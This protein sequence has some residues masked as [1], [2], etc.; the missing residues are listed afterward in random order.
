MQQAQEAAAEAEAQ[1]N[2]VFRLVEERR[3]VEL[4]LT[5]SVPERLVFVG[6]HRIESGEDHRLDSLEAGQRRSRALGF[7]NGIAHA[8]V[9]DPLNVGNDE[10]DVTRGQLVQHHRFGSERAQLFDFVN[11]VVRA[12]ANTRVP[13]DAAFHHAHQHHRAPVGVEPRV[14]DERAQRRFSGAARRRHA[15]H[16]GLEHLLNAQAALGA[17][18]Q[19]VAGRDSQHVFDLFLD[20]F[21]LCG[22][23]VNLVNHRDDGEIV[24]GG[25]KGVG[26]R[27]RLDPL[28]RIHHE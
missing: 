12:E 26:N 15:P 20:L 23:Q 6:E 24:L 4:E 17:D 1:G 22:R 2:G 13:R 5:E 8:G 16:Y 10:A 21:E 28:A 14:E 7:N 19:R 27:L 25:E 9:G 18:R 11:F 3:V